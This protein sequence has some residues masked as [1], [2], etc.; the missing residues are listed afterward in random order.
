MEMLPA[1]CL[2]VIKTCNFNVICM[3]LYRINWLSYFQAR[4]TIDLLV[5]NSGGDIRTAINGL[6][7]SCLKGED[8][9]QLTKI[10]YNKLLQT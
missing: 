10:N 5:Q 8:V 3:C 7:F 2:I 6:Q 4:K 9:K 1:V